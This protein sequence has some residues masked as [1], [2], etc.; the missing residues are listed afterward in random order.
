MTIFF[1]SNEK[2]VIANG[3]NIKLDFN[4]FL[5]KNNSNTLAV[6]VGNMLH[7]TT[8]CNRDRKLLKTSRHSVFT[9]LSKADL[10]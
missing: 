7:C 5:K 3:K 1:L 6:D 9:E 8:V 4:L 2:T 10:R